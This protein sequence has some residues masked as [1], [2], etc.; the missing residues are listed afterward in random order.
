M[1][2][3]MCENEELA[4]LNRERVKEGYGNQFYAQ[5]A[6]AVAQWQP[7]EKA[8]DSI[9]LGKLPYIGKIGRPRLDEGVDLVVE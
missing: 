1:N 5:Q 4:C 3:A 6:N 2:K 7:G 8:P 9:V